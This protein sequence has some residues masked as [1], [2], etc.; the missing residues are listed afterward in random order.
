[1]VLK[2]TK[3]VHNENVGVP[4]TQLKFLIYVLKGREY[5]ALNC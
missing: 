3:R 5:A 4:V 2:S 1:M